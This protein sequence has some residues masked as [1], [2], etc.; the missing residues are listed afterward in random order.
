M[1]NFYIF[2]IIIGKILHHQ[3]FSPLFDLWR[4]LEDSNLMLYD[5]QLGHSPNFT[6]RILQKY[7]CVEFLKLNGMCLFGFSVLFLWHSL[8]CCIGSL[9]CWKENKTEQMRPEA[10][11]SCYLFISVGLVVQ[12][13]QV[14]SL[15]EINE[16]RRIL[17]T[18]TVLGLIHSLRQKKVAQ[19]SQNNL[20][21]LALSSQLAGF[22]A[23]VFTLG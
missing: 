9:S 20:A 7:T 6:N 16:Y 5:L 10:S 4:L 15:K 11:K 19:A 8:L 12:F 22:F 2:V 13:V 17:F 21:T 18:V 23:N 1:V 3:F 14:S